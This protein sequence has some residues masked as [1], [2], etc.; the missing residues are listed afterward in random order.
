MLQIKKEGII[1]KPTSR[2]FENQSVFNPGVY[3]DGQYVHVFYRAVNKKYISTLGYAKLKGPLEVV[4]R[5]K[6]PFLKP[7]YKYEKNGLEDPRVVKIKD[8]FYMTY[9]VHDGKNA[10]TAYSYGPDL[11]KLERGGI[12]TPQISYNSVGKLFNY[13]KL[14]DQ[15]YFYKSYYIDT[16]ARDVLL[17]DKDGFLFPQK[18]KRK[19]AL[20]HRILPDIQVIYFNNFAQLKDEKFWRENIKKLSKFVILEGVHGFESRNIGGGAPPIKTKAGW[21]LIYHGVTPLNKG[22]T[23]HAGAALLDLKDPT[24]VIARLPYPLFSPEEDFEHQGQVHNVVF[25]TGTA[26]FDDRLY[27]YY[28]AADT[29]V[30]V[31]SVNL[32]SL[33]QELLKNKVEK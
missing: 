6:K 22:R 3:Q 9:V 29:F 7:K 18:I 28:G 24:K 8:T 32:N 21:L 13:S 31:A 4:E 10:L 12:I 19:F 20:V 27:I 14:D 17:W 33:I 5:W 2:D 23:Y 30:A 1:L 11:F 16:I 25:P 26:I 15:Y